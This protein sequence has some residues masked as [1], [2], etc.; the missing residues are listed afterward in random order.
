MPKFHTLTISDVRKETEDTVSLAFSI[1]EEI[2]GDFEF[3]QGQYLTLRTDI[4]GEDVRRSYSICSGV[5]EDEL[6]VAIKKVPGGLFSTFANESLKAGDQLEVMAPMGRFY[7]PLE[8]TNEKHYVGFAA[9]SG[10]TPMMSLIKSTLVKEPKSTFTL[11]YG[12]KTSKTIIFRDELEDLKDR[13]LSKLR[14]FHLLTQEMNDVPL[15]SGRIDGERCDKLCQTLINPQEVDEFF[16]CGP[17]SMINA[18]R[19]SLKEQGVE[20]GKVHFEL[21]TSPT[22]GPIKEQV[23]AKEEK[24]DG[25]Q[26]AVEIILDG[27]RLTFDLAYD[28]D[29]ILDAALAK[30]AD[31]PFSCKGGVCCTCRAKLVEGEV[32]MDVNYSLEPDEVERGFILTCQAHPRTEKIVVDFDQQ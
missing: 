6:R 20:E 10:I 25:E 19:G 9:G 7:T 29:Y 1:P 28:G 22:S 14:V 32:K 12:N 8:E 30:G 3:I 15:L 17:E 27:N 21:F 26:A 24:F 2:K 13:N 4:K 11:F 18:V 31:L 5:G 16:I 23:A